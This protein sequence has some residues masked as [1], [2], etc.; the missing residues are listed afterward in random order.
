MYQRFGCGHTVRLDMWKDDF[1]FE[2]PNVECPKCAR[3]RKIVGSG[4]LVI[5]R[6]RS[7]L[8]PKAKGGPNGS[9]RRVRA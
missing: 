6:D 1:W 8:V 2:T 3:R 4:R 5:F 9:A 7:L